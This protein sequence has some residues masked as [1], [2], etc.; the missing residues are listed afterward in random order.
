MGD[1]IS[2]GLDLIGGILT[3]QANSDIANSANTAAQ[4][5]QDQA[6]AFNAQQYATRYQTTVKDLEAAGLNPM[7]AYG[8][9]AGAPIAANAAPVQMAA[10]RVNA[11][12]SAGQAYRSAAYNAAQIKLADEQVQ[13]TNA[14]TEVYRTQGLKNTAEALN[15]AKNTEKQGAEIETLRKM[16]EVQAAQILSLKAGASA[17]S[18][19]AGKDIAATEGKLPVQLPWWYQKLENSATN[20]AQN[21]TKNVSNWTGGIKKDYGKFQNFREQM[22]GGS[23]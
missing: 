6:N 7:L 19:S 17:S 13:A 21:F 16:L 12:A 18:A 20:A 5:R 3:N 1:L 14:Q 2:G 9:G 10:P 15:I 4:Q 11:L 23:R 8:Q 22:L